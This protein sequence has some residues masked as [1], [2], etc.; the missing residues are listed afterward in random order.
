[1]EYLSFFKH[2]YFEELK[3]QTHIMFTEFKILSVLVDILIFSWLSL[4]GYF[5]YK[6]IYLFFL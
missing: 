4:A 3:I 1:M 6:L 5:L 2:Y